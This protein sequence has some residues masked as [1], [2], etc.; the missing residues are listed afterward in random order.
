MEATRIGGEISKIAMIAKIWFRL[1]KDHILEY[2]L[3]IKTPRLA[4]FK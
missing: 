1:V 2:V 4:K 3:Y